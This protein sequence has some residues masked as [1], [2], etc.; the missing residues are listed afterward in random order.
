MSGLIPDFDTA[1][2]FILAG[3]ATF[4]VVSLKT[5][6]RFT[7]RVRACRKPDE[8][9]N[10]APTHFVD[11]LTGPDNENS[12]QYLG[13]IREGVF[14]HGKKSRISPEAPSAR[15]FQWL[16]SHLS[17]GMDFT[18]HAELWHEGRCG[19]CGRKLTVPESIDRGIGPECAK[20][21]L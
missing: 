16:W 14:Q 9:P 17:H 6:T 1:R 13:Y 18:K 5:N 7:F 21:V 19:R 15:A 4:T 2:Q 8:M 20:Y 3:R 12:F 11:L 10:G